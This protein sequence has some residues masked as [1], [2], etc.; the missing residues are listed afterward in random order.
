MTIF[1]ILKK[2]GLSIFYYFQKESMEVMPILTCNSLIIICQV[3]IFFCISGHF[4]TFY[5]F[6]LIFL[7]MLM[8]EV[9][10]SLIIPLQGCVFY[11]LL[12]RTMSSWCWIEVS[13]FQLYIRL[14]LLCFRLECFQILIFCVTQGYMVFLF[15]LGE[16]CDCSMKLIEIGFLMWSLLGRS[17]LCVVPTHWF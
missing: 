1:H 4:W 2:W 15:I 11:L 17:C 12:V 7:F 6:S 9:L 10:I 16:E 13:T 5:F 8:N 3:S 14:K